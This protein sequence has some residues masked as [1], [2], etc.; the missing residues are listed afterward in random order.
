MAYVSRLNHR[1]S[2]GQNHRSL[3]HMRQLA[4]IS[5]PKVLLKHEQSFFREVLARRALRHAGKQKL[6]QEWNVLPAFAKSRHI[7]REHG[8]SV[9]QIKPEGACGGTLLEVLVRSGNYA[10]IHAGDLVVANALQLAAFQ[11]AQH[12]GL[13][14]QRHLSD[15][16]QKERSPMRGFNAA[17]PRPHSTGERSACVS[18]ELGLQQRLGM[19]AQLSTTIDFAAR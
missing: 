6:G 7:D 3:Q 10:H 4:H 5:G 12:L 2:A 18:K 8:Q 19:A 13:K 11:E 17:H 1:R 9:V 14:C 15:L 16:I